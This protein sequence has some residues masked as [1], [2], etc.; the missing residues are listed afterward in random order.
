MSKKD[1]SRFFSDSKSAT[2][3]LSS[4]VDNIKALQNSA[5]VSANSKKH[6]ADSVFG[7]DL[8]F[9]VDLDFDISRQND[10]SPTTTATTFNLLDNSLNSSSLFY[11]NSSQLSSS[12][13]L[14][15]KSS[16]TAL[17]P[18]PSNFSFLNSKPSKDIFSNPV[19]SATDPAPSLSSSIP[20]SFENRSG[21]YV[22]NSLLD[23]DELNSASSK[24]FS[25]SLRQSS[26]F[27]R[28]QLGSDLPSASARDT[29]SVIYSQTENSITDI[30]AQLM[31]TAL[32]ESDNDDTST[33]FSKK[34]SS[35]L[36][37]SILSFHNK[38]SITN[39]SANSA[40]IP[41]T[42]ASSTRAV[43]TPPRRAPEPRP[44]NSDFNSIEDL[45][46][47]FNNVSLNS[48]KNPRFLDT[49]DRLPENDNNYFASPYP[50]LSSNYTQN[51]HPSQSL[52]SNAWYSNQ[53]SFVVDDQ[54]QPALNQIPK[55][56]ENDDSMYHLI[57]QN[58]TLKEKH[59]VPIDIVNSNKPFNITPYPQPFSINSDSTKN[60]F[61]QSTV[62]AIDQNASFS[63]HGHNPI[64]SHP[65]IQT[66]STSYPNNVPIPFTQSQHQPSFSSLNQ[67]FNIPHSA[68]QYS[69]ST[70]QNSFNIAP[71]PNN[72]A[73]FRPHTYI[74]PEHESS[75]EFYPYS[76]TY[77]MPA[78]IPIQQSKV[79][80]QPRFQPIEN[81]PF[82]AAEQPVRSTVLEEFR[83]NKTRKYELKD[84]RGYI[85]EFSTDQYGSR[86]IQQKLEIS[87]SEDKLM[88]FQE[89]L[90]HA[91]HLMSD[92][93]GNY[94]IQKFFDHGSAPQKHMLALQMSNHILT[95]SLQMYGCRV[96]QKALEHVG[97]DL[98]TSMI[99]ELDNHVLKCVKDQN[100]NHVIQKTI[101]C[102]PAD[103]IGFIIDSFQGQVFQLATH[104]Y[105][106][107][108]IQRLF[109]H[110]SDEKTR[111]LLVEL[112]R[113]IPGLVQDQYGNYVIQHILEHG[114]PADRTMIINK[115]SGNV[116]RL[117]KHKFASNVVEKCITYGSPTER[118]SLISEVINVKQDDVSGLALMMKDQY[119]NY[120]VQKM[121]DVVGD[122]QRQDLLSAL[123]P[124]LPSLRRFTY[125]RHLTNKVE[126]LLSNK[127]SSS[128]SSANSSNNT[129]V[130]ANGTSS[131][132]QSTITDVSDSSDE[133]KQKNDNPNDQNNIDKCANQAIPIS[134]IGSPTSVSLS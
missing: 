110:C 74:N 1:S 18:P 9:E 133:P 15:P 126:S 5:F 32:I 70:S 75:Q 55:A 21:Y 130:S 123:Q 104:P 98:Q 131:D 66:P 4:N 127:N 105:G 54:Q 82:Q 58:E 13:S 86:F 16:S 69:A 103:R 6:S 12:K 38:P 88:V 30:N 99:K 63:T 39:F 68:Q 3:S 71:Q 91:L 8:N 94:V 34:A 102:V 14:N 42:A 118:F 33:S 36:T 45:S 47:H 64:P 77:N 108:V 114:D 50:V 106:C 95:L 89:I 57:Y 41:S 101:E 7:P 81:H 24:L 116:L 61:W 29:T 49:S 56:M 11:P 128:A 79:S 100:G 76:Q 28:N 121:L 43:S 35:S 90:P 59:S 2:V 85:V 27:K 25:S 109:E 124:H 17:F 19:A 40:S 112:Q 20:P 125:G 93:F 52:D 44:V 111:S 119:A 107:R 67:P 92:V 80:Q 87:S 73:S 113:Y 37:H 51:F 26:S 65:K 122:D 62:P 60:S 72:L 22:P 78:S 83:N 84:I 129:N 96:V 53:K 23:I 120:V 117:S 132:N 97:I 115:I 31:V 48:T 134:H 10:V 46:K